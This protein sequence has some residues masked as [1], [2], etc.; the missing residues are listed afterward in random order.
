MLGRTL[1]LYVVA[2]LSACLLAPS[3]SFAEDKV[4]AFAT[5]D[6][7]MNAAIARAR[8]TLP[9][10]WAK[11]SNP[12][13]NEEDFALKLAISDGNLTEHFW[14]DEIEGDAAAA[15]CTI[16]NE[17]Q[18]VHIVEYLQ[19]IEVDPALISDW[20]YM[21]HGKIE[22]AETLRVIVT[23]VSEEEAAFYKEMLAP[24]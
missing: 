3:H 12:S 16:A 10:F 22:G 2:C 4:T 1:P 20:M 19:R 13:A 21:R 23:R 5:T 7:E 15:T 6:A 18:E 11:F 14:C 24:R 8:E 17:P 9:T